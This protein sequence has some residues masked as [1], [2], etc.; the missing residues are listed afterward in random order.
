MRS[1]TERLGRDAARP[2][3]FAKAVAE[4]G[5]R[6]GTVFVNVIGE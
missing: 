6:E 5:F 2:A 3:E 4:D 1:S